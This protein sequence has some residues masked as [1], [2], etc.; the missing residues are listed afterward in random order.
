MYDF[1]VRVKAM[2]RVRVR[3]KVRVK[4]RVRVTT[5]VSRSLTLHRVFKWELYIQSTSR[6]AYLGAKEDI[7]TRQLGHQD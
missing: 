6:K 7:S 3:V 1:P 2:F 5:G 4:V